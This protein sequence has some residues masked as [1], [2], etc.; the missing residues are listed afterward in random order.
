MSPLVLVGFC[1]WWWCMVFRERVLHLR[2]SGS[3]M[4]CFD[5][6]CCELAVVATGQPCLIVGDFNV[7]HT[8][9][10]VWQRESLLACDL[11]CKRLGPVRLMLPRPPA[12]ILSLPL[13]EPGGTLCD[14]LSPGCCSLGLVQGS[15]GSVDCSPSCCQSLLFGFTSLP[16]SWVG[17]T[18][19]T[20]NSRS[21]DVRRVC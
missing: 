8:K 19:K 1:I 4:H 13:E 10:F 18:D 3:L 12:S 21:A 17:V 5:A 14:W 11:I 6:V 9:I 7:E 20:R 2:N 15:L 16:A